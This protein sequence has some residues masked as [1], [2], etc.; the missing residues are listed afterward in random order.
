MFHTISF[1]DCDNALGDSPLCSVR[2][3]YR[4]IY[5]LTVG[6]PIVDISGEKLATAVSV[7]SALF[8]G[9]LILLILGT[10]AMLSLFGLSDDYESM[11]ATCFWEPKL[12][13]ILFALRDDGSRSKPSRLESTWTIA[14]HILSGKADRKGTYWYAC[15][16]QKPKLFKLC[17][18]LAAALAVPIWLVIGLL[19]LGLL[20]PPQVRRFL[21]EPSRRYRLGVNKPNSATCRDDAQI[22]S[23]RNELAQVRDLSYE[24]SNDIQRDIRKLQE[25]LRLATME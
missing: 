1:V 16:T 8:L 18:W 13:C 2:E 23:I 7:L 3:C 12:S 5:F 10:I 17:I 21:F 14:M 15:F 24:R 20:W 22:R 11:A 6:E 9:F 25:I 19:T 4:L